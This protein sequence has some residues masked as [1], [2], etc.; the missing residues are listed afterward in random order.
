MIDLELY[1]SFPVVIWLF[2]LY[3]PS[4]SL[5]FYLNV[6]YCTCILYFRLAFPVEIWLAA[7]TDHVI[8]FPFGKMFQSE[9]PESHVTGAASM[10]VSASQPDVEPEVN[11]KLDLE[12][13]VMISSSLAVS[14]IWI[15]AVVEPEVE[16]EL[17]PE[18]EPDS[19][20]FRRIENRL[21]FR[22]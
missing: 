12:P 3:S 20:I 8:L 7:R 1:T 6:L 13:E 16:P 14:N 18:I 4:F 19:M 21:Q 22:N 9:A 2:Q 15:L 17:K 11:S 5:S 10:F